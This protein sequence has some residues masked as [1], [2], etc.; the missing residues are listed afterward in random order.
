MCQIATFYEQWRHLHFPSPKSNYFPK[1]EER[2]TKDTL[3]PKFGRTWRRCQII[4]RNFG[5]P[6]KVPNH[7]LE[8][9]KPLQSCQIK[10]WRTAQKLPNHFG[11]AK[12][13]FGGPS[14][15]LEVPNHF[16]RCQI[17]FGRPIL[18]WRSC[19]IILEV[20]NQSWTK[21]W[22]HSASEKEELESSSPYAKPKQNKLN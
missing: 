10:F 6:K 3:V 9:R 18:F 1:D 4:W 2:R 13:K 22:G 15:G 20:P 8:D 5:G 21:W 7:V 19:Q 16:W 17:K 14:R 12:S 11:G